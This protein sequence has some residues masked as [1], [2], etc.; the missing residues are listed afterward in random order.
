MAD[1]ADGAGE[2]G[3]AGASTVPGGVPSGGPAVRRSDGSTVRR[4]DGST[5]RRSDGPT[6]D[7][8]IR[9]KDKTFGRFYGIMVRADGAFSK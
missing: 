8:E 3:E 4:F 2:A 5:V 9:E 7:G 1:G 6:L